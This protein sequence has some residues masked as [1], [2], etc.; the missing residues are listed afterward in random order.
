[1]IQ[2]NCLQR[3]HSTYFPAKCVQ[4]RE[5]LGALTRR[6]RRFALFARVKF[7]VLRFARPRVQKKG[8]GGTSVLLLMPVCSRPS[9]PSIFLTRVK[10]AFRI[11]TS[12]CVP[13]VVMGRGSCPIHRIWMFLPSLLIAVMPVLYVV[14]MIESLGLSNCF[15]PR[16]ELYPRG[17]TEP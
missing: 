12:N 6:L 9:K 14:R 10:S 17:K 5:E 11:C 1:M 13:W 2:L 7:C 15:L 8:W 16:A 4:S 3:L